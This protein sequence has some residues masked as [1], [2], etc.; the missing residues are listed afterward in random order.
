MGREQLSID[1]CSVEAGSVQPGGILVRRELDTIISDV[2]TGTISEEMPKRE[3]GWMLVSRSGL[4]DRVT[5][6]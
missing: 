1:V 6:V 3:I 5:R 4:P 2:V